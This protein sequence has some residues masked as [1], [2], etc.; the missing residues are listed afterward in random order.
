MFGLA[1]ADT[2]HCLGWPLLLPA[3]GFYHQVKKVTIGS[4][5]LY[6]ATVRREWLTY[7]GKYSEK[8]IQLPLFAVSYELPVE[9]N[10]HSLHVAC[11]LGSQGCVH[12][13]TESCKPCLYFTSRSTCICTP[14]WVIILLRV[15]L[16]D[17]IHAHSNLE[18]AIG[19][20]YV[21]LNPHCSVSGHFVH[22]L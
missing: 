4:R 12:Y 22:S 18:V 1:W 2:R 10:T 15:S 7:C 14:V 3:T 5:W 11:V 21:R 17:F 6:M 19:Q 20:N 9:G 16:V 13:N 8:P